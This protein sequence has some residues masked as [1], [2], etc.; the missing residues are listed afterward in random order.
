ME[1]TINWAE[2]FGPLRDTVLEAVKA[3]I[4]IGVA[5]LAVIFGVRKAA[6]LIRGLAGR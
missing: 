1:T 5:I 2:L 3:V 6:Q 4:P